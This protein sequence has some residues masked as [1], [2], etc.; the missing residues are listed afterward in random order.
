MRVAAQVAST[1][2]TALLAFLG[3]LTWELIALVVSFVALVLASVALARSGHRDD[4]VA[5]WKQDQ[6]ARAQAQTEE[7]SG[8]LT[9]E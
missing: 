8:D 4:E 9:E 6:E 5:A 2:A 1:L 7:L 3:L